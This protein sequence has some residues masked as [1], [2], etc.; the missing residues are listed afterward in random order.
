M[1]QNSMTW[2]SE[3]LLSNS[4]DLDMPLPENSI[5]AEP[6]VVPAAPVETY[7]GIEDVSSLIDIEHEEK[8]K[9]QMKPEFH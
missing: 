9:K 5:W 4:P 2:A 1:T 8:A 7:L 3:L 6:P